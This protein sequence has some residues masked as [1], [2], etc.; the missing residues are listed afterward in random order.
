LLTHTLREHVV[1]ASMVS[2]AICKNT[3]GTQNIQGASNNH[4]KNTCG[5][6]W[7]TIVI[8]TGQST[9]P[10][11]LRKHSRERLTRC[12]EWKARDPSQKHKP[13]CGIRLNLSK[14][15]SSSRFSSMP[16]RRDIGSSHR[17]W[18]YVH[19]C[20]MNPSYFM[21][22]LQSARAGSWRGCSKSLQQ[23]KP[24][25]TK[26]LCG[27]T[28]AR[29]CRISAPVRERLGLE[30]SSWDAC[31]ALALRC[32]CSRYTTWAVACPLRAR[33]A[34]TH[35][36]TQGWAEKAGHWGEGR[37]HMS[38]KC[39]QFT[40]GHSG[41]RIRRTCFPKRARCQPRHWIAH[42]SQHCVCDSCHSRR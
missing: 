28:V 1:A 19:V 22:N 41:L 13:C 8:A 23:N 12:L 21:D 3:L 24:V 11:A 15:S 7:S 18:G 33:H 4:M 38:G 5:S 29:F 16:N 40:L 6:S 27:A 42:A 17:R 9:P 25:W 10:L 35:K 26:L 31:C 2:W 32:G 37:T 30:T 34:C 14:H 36:H 20:H 39:A